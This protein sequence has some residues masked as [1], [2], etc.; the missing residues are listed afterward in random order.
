MTQPH[1]VTGAGLMAFWA[2]IAP[3][4]VLRYQEWH[5]CEHVPERVNIPGFL[6]GRRYRERS[7]EPSFLMFYETE[8]PAVLGSD[9]YL[10][11]LNNPTP[12]TRE[13]LQYFRNPARNIYSLIADRGAPQLNP[14]PY[15]FT[16]RFNLDA[17]SEEKVL[18]SY[19]DRWLPAL[20]G[21]EGVV[22]ARLYRV[23]EDATSIVTSERKIY[24]GGLG[25]QR[26]LAL[27]ESLQPISSK[28]ESCLAGEDEARR[29]RFDNSCWLEFGYA[30][31]AAPTPGKSA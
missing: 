16:S 7:G 20:A 30:K 17:A 27:V 9:A 6:R 8:T 4:Y 24:G 5:N 1:E 10:A 26:Y 13:A 28:T 18:A 14:A 22:R 15:A 29:D 3:D 19:C 12:W 23:D 25:G 2:D 31:Q 21:A 11:A